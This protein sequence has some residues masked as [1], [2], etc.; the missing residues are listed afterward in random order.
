MY[1]TADVALA[2]G[3]TPKT[4]DNLVRRYC[5]GAIPAGSQ[6]AS[7]SIPSATVEVIALAL[8]LKRDLGMPFRRGWQIAT[9]LLH[10]GAQRVPVGILGTLEYDVPRL[11]AVVRQALADSVQ[12]TSP[13][14]RG[15]PPAKA[16][17]GAL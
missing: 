16:K 10:G 4:I 6:G 12:D 14:R 3:T 15:R 8:L 2:L 17:R 1:T 7:R 11:K 5:R 13:I 9:E